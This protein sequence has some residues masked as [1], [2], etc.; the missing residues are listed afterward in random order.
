[1]SAIK[2]DSRPVSISAYLSRTSY[3]CT[4]ASYSELDGCVVWN[5][6]NT[7]FGSKCLAVCAQAIY[8]LHLT[9]SSVACL[10]LSD[11]SVICH[12][13]Y[14]QFPI[15]ACFFHVGQPGGTAAYLVYP[16]AYIGRRWKFGEVPCTERTFQGNDFELIATVKMETRYTVEGLFGREFPSI[17]TH[18]GVMAGPVSRKTLKVLEIFLRYLEKWPLTAKFSKFGCKSF[19]RDTDRRVVFKFREIWPTGNRWN[20]VLLTWQKIRLAL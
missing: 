18:C 11:V 9:M 1:M 15:Q 13:T 12:V 8:F 14:L 20:S 17:Y 10:R 2:T 6:H 19:Y 16:I 5:A 7:V 4:T 3:Y